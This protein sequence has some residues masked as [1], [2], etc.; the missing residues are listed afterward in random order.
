LLQ[1][2]L[3][4]AEVAAAW[5]YGHWYLPGPPGWWIAGF[6]CLLIVAFLYG[7]RW[8]RVRQAEAL[9]L[10]VNFGL[11][12]GL[13]PRGPQPLVCEVI[14][15][16]HGLA[17]VIHCPN[18][19]TLG[20][21]VGCLAG[22]DYAAAAVCDS[23]W[24]TGSRRLD[25]LIVSHADSD[26]CN[27]I[28]PL[29]ERLTVGT[30]CSHRTILTGEPAIVMQS[31]E[32]W[33]DAGGPI[34]LVSAGDQIDVDPA[35]SVAV[36]QP[37]NDERFQRDNANSVVVQVEYAGRKIL[38]TGDLERGGLAALLQRPRSPVDVLVAPH[39]GS[40][41]ANPPELA[42]WTNPA[43]VVAS[44]ADRQARS[45]LS[46]SYTDPTVVL[47]TAETGCVRCEIHADGTWHVRTFRPAP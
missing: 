13:W 27:G 22:G 17:V 18:G 45:R 35:V 16:G 5:S 30:L 4:L 28:V 47:N 19:K 1:G 26:H 38:L 10:W 33:S 24:R 32:A 31:L 20:Y 12:C 15:V 39:H 6:Y 3:S 44:S 8:P 34:E 41:A 21:D 36:W 29:T 9:L 25:A 37:T 23:V 46:G 2:L 40:K 43:L 11:A 7:S 14:A 42:A